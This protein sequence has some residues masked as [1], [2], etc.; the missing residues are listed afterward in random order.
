VLA[1]DRPFGVVADLALYGDHADP[2]RV[3][4]LPTRPRVARVGDAA[5]LSFVKFR[6]DD[7]IADGG[8]GLLSFTAELHA[9]DE[10]LDEARRHVVRL[11]VAEPVLARLDVRAGR[12]V[13]AAALQEGDGFVER[14][15][16]EV[17]PDLAGS[18][19]AVFSLRL[20]EQGARLVEAMLD[21]NGPR[22][23]G[24]R[25]ELEFLGLRPAL[26]VKLRADYGR[27]YDELSWGL[28]VGVA[29]QGVGVRAGV[30]SATKKLVEEGAIQVEVL[31]FSDDADLR[32]RVDEAVRWFQEKLL[33]EF[34][35]TRL[36]NHSRESLIDKAIAAAAQLGTTLAGA[37]ASSV[38]AAR[39]AEM[40]GVSPELLRALQ[41]AGGGGPGAT[42]S[43]GGG[44]TFAAKL[45]F[46]LRD[47]HQD[48]R[49]V[50]ELDWSEA[51]AEK[52]TAAPQG[53]LADMGPQ[54]T[55]VEA[56][57][58]GELWRKLVVNVRPLGDFRALGVERLVVQ[59]AHPGEDDPSATTAAFTFEPARLEPQRFAAWT[60]G[61]PPRYRVQAETHFADDG[62]WPG[63]P[64]F[65]GAWKS[66]QAL[67]LAVHPLT[68]VPRVELE[69]SP[70]T[71]DLTETPQVQVDVRIDGEVIATRML[72][73]ASPTAVV[74]QRLMPHP[75]SP[76][77]EVPA[78]GG[79]PR[80]EAR[81]TWFHPG[82]S[83]TEGEWAPVEGSVLLV[84]APWRSRRT[85][86][87]FPLLPP[88][89]IDA[90]VTLTLT[91]G[92]PSRAV[93]VQ[94]TPGERGATVVSLPSLAEHPP[95]VRV[96]VLVIRGD[97]ST[98]LGV[99]FETR[100]PVVLVRDRDGEHR[101][102]DVRLLAGARLSDHGLIAVQVQLLDDAD[103]VVDAVVF[104]ESQRDPGVLLVP[105]ERDGTVKVRY[106]VTRYGLDGRPSVGAV[107]EGAPPQLLVPAVAS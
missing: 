76:P 47:I 6:G 95:P 98:F 74:R 83:R 4:Y 25:Y 30:E 72:T 14:M 31:H 69:L 73:A 17:T 50:V 92:Q 16:G 37:L 101:K 100:D 82:G 11:G 68:D 3:Y 91:E 5:E 34:F 23:L 24:V 107:L 84:H 87:V 26:R 70:G 59:L 93:N 63:P 61:K 80:V 39:L 12:A 44:S 105:V 22:A 64:V 35:E 55:I 97:G 67:E 90:S 71:V 13:L 52:R 86:R 58:R 36:E 79:G 54:P 77:A 57:A 32:A 10:A 94:L 41:G 18:C 104:T 66:A 21:T 96:D 53:L 51:R 60:D 48:E 2:N 9:S 15:V 99:P 45:E 75:A 85:I 28:Q 89:F 20:G 7:P 106:R 102:V 38:L 8:A 46:S 49:R 42:G 62:P 103:A 78:A 43:G 65:T 27:I 40:L 29:Y 88:D 19:R 1:L 81:T 33:A 56:D